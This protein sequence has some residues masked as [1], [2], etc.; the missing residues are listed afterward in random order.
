MGHLKPRRPPKL[1]APRRGTQNRAVSPRSFLPKKVTKALSLCRTLRALR[2]PVLR[3]SVRTRKRVGRGARRVGEAE[4]TLL[5]GKVLK[6]RAGHAVVGAEG[7]FDVSTGLTAAR[8]IIFMELL[9]FESA[10]VCSHSPRFTRVFIILLFSR[11]LRLSSYLSFFL[12]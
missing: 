10:H 12:I 7:K 6:C 8:C 2:S 9:F 11:L 4:R 5:L 3:M 1:P